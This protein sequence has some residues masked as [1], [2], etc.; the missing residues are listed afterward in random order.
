MT[1]LTGKT[2][3]VTGG[4]SG[5]GAAICDALARSGASV[6]VA[7]MREEKAAQTARRIT[8]QGGMPGP[9]AST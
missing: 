7:D 4:G 6:A 1:D 8:E 3:L 5:L 2:A 9:C